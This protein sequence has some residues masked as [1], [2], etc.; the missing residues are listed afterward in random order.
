VLVTDRV[1]DSVA[2]KAGI[3]KGDRIFSFGGEPVENSFDLIYATGNLRPG[4]SATIELKREDET[5][6]VEA[7]FVAPGSKH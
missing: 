1:S 7:Y 6:V 4:D 3:N 5:L 2:A